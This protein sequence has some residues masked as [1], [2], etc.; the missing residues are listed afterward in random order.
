[1][2]ILAIDIG[3]SSISMGQ[4]AADKAGLE[5]VDYA[6]ESLDMESTSDDGRNEHITETIRYILN[7]HGI[8]S[9]PVLISVPGQSVFSRFVKLPSVNREKIMQIVKYEAQQNVPFPIDEVVWDYQLVSGE[10][11]EIDAMLAA[12]KTDIIEDLLDAVV[13]AGLQPELVDVAPMSLY[14]AVKYNYADLPDCTIVVDIGARSTDLV[15]IESGRVFSRSIPVGGNTITQQ[16]MKSFDLSFADAEEMKKAQA[17]VSFGGAYES[18]PSVVADKVSKNVRSVMTRL[19]AEINRS[20]NF[21]KTQQAGSQP[22]L[23]LLTGGSSIITYTDSFLKEKLNVEVDYLNPFLNVSV[24]PDISADE[25]GARAHVMGE[26]VGLALRKVL[27]CP[28]EMNL[29]PPKIIQDRDF[30]R[31]VPYFIVSSFLVVLLL[32][33]W[34][35]YFYQ[36]KQIGLE[37]EGKIDGAVKRLETFADTMNKV[38]KDI[39]QVH[40]KIDY[41]KDLIKKRTEWSLLLKEIY[42]ITP[43]GVWIKK[44]T[45]QE[46]VDQNKRGSFII[47]TI[48]VI[49]M[50]YRDFHERDDIKNLINENWRNSSLFTD[51]TNVRFLTVQRVGGKGIPVIEFEIELKLEKP[52]AL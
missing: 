25:I 44:M 27:T 15:F 12:I 38:E 52:I 33:V 10:D 23:V 35:I 50:A 20:I 7:E 48:L 3:A 6:I 24:S 18:P 14:N 30:I 47:D 19:H 32:L 5:L 1:M 29:L 37:Q 2:N 34:W 39:K 11:G 49:G 45:P 51:K 13:A 8:G 17:F 22:G 41:V 43:D 16:V 31:K 36:L 21:Y 4:F 26:I 28:I 46:R 42:K 40:G 9:M